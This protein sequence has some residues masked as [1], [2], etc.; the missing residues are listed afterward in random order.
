MTASQRK[1]RT[2]STGSCQL[3]G[4]SYGKAAMTRHLEACLTTHAPELPKGGRQ[5]RQTRLFHLLVEGRGMPEYWLHLE[6]PDKARLK[7]LD[8][9]LRDIWLE[10]CGHLSAFA[11]DNVDYRVDADID[12]DDG[13]DEDYESMRCTL[14]KVLRPD[15]TFG[16]EYDFGTT[17]H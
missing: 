3:C 5:P 7:D 14:A 4:D 6:A 9:F 13:L 11:I 12:W 1:K 10:C 17:T 8:D 16:H 2:V 15:I